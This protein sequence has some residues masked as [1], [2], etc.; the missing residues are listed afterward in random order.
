MSRCICVDFACFYF[1]LSSGHSRTSLTSLFYVQ[2]QIPGLEE[3]Q[4]FVPC[5]LMN[6]RPIILQ[7]LNAAAG[8][9]C[10]K[11]PDEIAE[12]EAYLLMSKHGAG[13]SATDSDWAPWDGELLKL[14]PQMETVDTLG[15]MKVSDFKKKKKIKFLHVRPV[16]TSI[17]PVWSA[18]GGEHALDRDAVSSPGGPAK[19]LSAVNGGCA[20][21]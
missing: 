1:F 6:Q 10:S 20:H 4:V 8:K 3:L 21:S 17:S 19:G 12:D 5:G 9:D 7:L 13:D 16:L 14:V 18:S 2:V 15:A 11:E